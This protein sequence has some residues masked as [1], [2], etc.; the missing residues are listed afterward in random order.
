MVGGLPAPPPFTAARATN[1]QTVL[2]T[3]T[4]PRS[5]FVG[6][7]PFPYQLYSD[8]TTNNNKNIYGDNDD[9]VASV[10]NATKSI[11]LYDFDLKKYLIY[12]VLIF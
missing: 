11:M 6:P 7:P 10:I 8:N 5:S 3:P 2:P 4:S 9:D 1:Y 12:V